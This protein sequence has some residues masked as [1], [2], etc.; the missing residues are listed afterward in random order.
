MAQH[1]V[2][3][4]P[5]RSYVVRVLQSQLQWQGLERFATVEGTRGPWLV[6][7]GPRSQVEHLAKEFWPLETVLVDFA[8]L[9]DQ[10]PLLVRA[11][12]IRQIVDS[13]HQLISL[14]WV[15]PLLAAMVLS[16]IPV[17]RSPLG[18]MS[19]AQKSLVLLA[20]AI[21]GS[22]HGY[23]TS[24]RRQLGSQGPSQILMLLIPWVVFLFAVVPHGLALFT[25]PTAWYWA[26]PGLS[27]L[28]NL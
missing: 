22:L 23:R 16:V 21:D 28:N 7:R 20:G 19:Q 4:G 8:Q 10:W 5:R 25:R 27:L 15:I 24:S 2:L 6:E 9:P 26:F 13:I 14:L 11:N 12:R 3:F 1:L 18:F 17:A